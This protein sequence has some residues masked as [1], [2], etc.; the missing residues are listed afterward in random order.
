MSLTVRVL[1]GLVAGFLLGLALAQSQAS[2][3]VSLVRIAGTVGTIFINLIRMTVIPLV[4]SMLIASV[5]SMAASG[6]LGRAGS[7]A[8][9]IALAILT[10]AA[11]MSAAIAYPVLSN[12]HI[13]ATATAA[14]GAS[15]TPIVPGATAGAAPTLS[16]WLIDLVP[17]NPIKAAADGAMLPLIIFTILFALTLARVEES[18]RAP[19]LRL[20]S[21]VADAMQR[22]V[23]A[24]LTLAP[25]GVFAL[26]IPLAAKLGVSAAGAV[27]VYIALVVSLTVL[28][29]VGILYPVGVALGPLSLRQFVAFAAPAQAVAFASRSSIAALPAMVESAEKAGLPPLVSSFILPI[30]ASL[31]RAGAAVAQTVGVL[32]LARLYGV[33]LSAAQLATVVF[34]VI[35]TT[36]AVPGIPGGSIIAMVPVLAAANLPIEGVGILLAVDAIPDMFRTTANVTGT[37]TLAAALSKREA[38]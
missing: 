13:D 26:A 18:R 28:V 15:R 19:V 14:L 32:F 37:M 29:A 36:F 11:L 16:Q 34:T 24:I 9:A 22:L 10:A 38:D 2:A 20:V 27:A 35:L 5:G 8:A 6:A 21:G 7:R 4:V 17:Q 33:P 12:L 1:V 25:I 3:A 23:A 31:F 30:G